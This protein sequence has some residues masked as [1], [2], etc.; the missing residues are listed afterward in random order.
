[1]GNLHP[2]C[3]LPVLDAPSAYQ[4]AGQD[5]ATVSELR[6][7]TWQWATTPASVPFCSIR[8]GQMTRHIRRRRHLISVPVVG[9]HTT[10]STR[11]SRLPPGVEKGHS[12]ARQLD[13]A[14]GTLF[15]REA[16]TRGGR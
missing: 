3:H 1:M 14:G 16:A 7:R 12:S 15:T 9:I 13:E 5:G 4:L 2:T 11:L 10:P 6:G 8:S